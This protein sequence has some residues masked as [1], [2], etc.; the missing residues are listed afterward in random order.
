MQCEGCGR[1][2]PEPLPK[3]CPHCGRPG[4]QEPAG[5]PVAGDALQQA[6]R[7][8]G[9]AAKVAQGAAAQVA[10]GFVRTVNDPNLVGRIPGRSVSI[11]G[12]A[13]MALAIILTWTKWFWGIGLWW[14]I[15]MLL[16]GA[17]VAAQEL[18]SGGLEPPWMASLP[19]QLFHP[20]IPPIFAALVTVH[21]FQLLRFGVVPLLWVGAALL[22][23]Y[24]QYRKAILAPNSF[25]QYFDFRLAWYGYRRYILL[26]ALLCLASLFFIWGKSAGHFMGGY[27]L[28]Y[29]SYKGGYEYNYNVTKYYYAGWELSGRSQGL[30][31]FVET[32]LLSLVAWSAFQGKGTVPSWF[33]QVAMG[34]AAFLSLWWLLHI[35]LHLG[36]LLFLLGVAAID[37]AVF[38]I[39]KGQ[40]AGQFDAD[41]VMQQVR[42]RR[43]K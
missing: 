20:L 2:L 41:S 19:T 30:V 23:G 6:A 27:D 5:A 12:L 38:M 21:A 18:R 3:F 42:S 22:L 16:G 33:N 4:A 25:G 10:A 34:L 13:L 11:A 39:Y 14:S 28:N 29:S 8:A 15:L 35:E 37:F 7:A 17:V 9:E 43:G 32:A 31:V 1:R 36:Q 26:G 40:H 24:D